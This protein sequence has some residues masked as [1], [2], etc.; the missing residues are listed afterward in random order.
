MKSECH[1]TASIIIPAHNEEAVIG[2]CLEGILECAREGEFQVVVV[3]NGCTDNTAS[4]ADTYSDVQVVDIP[5]ASKIQA[6]KRGDIESRYY[7][8]IYLDADI[9]VSAS[10]LRSLVKSLRDSEPR[11]GAPKA[12]FD[13]SRS[14]F[15]VRAFYRVWSLHPYFDSGRVGS[16]VIGANR[17]A[18]SRIADFPNITA[19]DEWVRVNFSA[20]ERVMAT[21]GFFVVTAPNTLRDLIKIKTRSRRG[22]LELQ[23][24]FPELQHDNAIGRMGLTKRILAR[25]TRLMDA[26]VYGYVVFRTSLGA[27][28]TLNCTE[29]RWE[30]DNSTRAVH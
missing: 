25:P 26:L 4:I 13:T 23:S 7:P 14:S 19:D 11:I 21:E 20:S 18:H 28:R 1:T 12:L 5:V 30:R 6:I 10:S 8:R 22:T 9:Q 2:R 17:V 24:K 3:C 27:R 15:S 16:G 29:F